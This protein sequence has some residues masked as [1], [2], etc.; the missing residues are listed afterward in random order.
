[1]SRI[2]QYEISASFQNVE[3]FVHPEVSVDRDACTDRHLLGPQGEHSLD[4]YRPDI[5]ILAETLSDVRPRERS[6]DSASATAL[7]QSSVT[8]SVI[9][10][11]RL[12]VVGQR[13][14]GA[15]DPK[16]TFGPPPSAGL[17]SKF[18]ADE[19]V[20]VLRRFIACCRNIG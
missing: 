10:G 2:V 7:W 11:G 6:R 8:M 1:V 19:L 16:R 4:A 5:I 13:P 3:G 9:S 12:E 17:S 14:N 15:I 20:L 18:R